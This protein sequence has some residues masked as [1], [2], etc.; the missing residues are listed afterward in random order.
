MSNPKSPSDYNTYSRE[1]IEELKAEMNGFPRSEQVKILAHITGISDRQARRIYSKYFETGVS[2]KEKAKDKLKKELNELQAAVPAENRKVNRLYWDIETSPNIG[3]FWKAGWDLNV[4]AESITQE[5]KIICIGYKWEHEDH[6]H[7]LHWDESQDD[8]ALLIKFLEIVNHADELIHHNGDRFDLPWFKTRCLFHGL[9]PMP[10]YKTIDS[11]AIARRKFYFNSNKLNYI[12]KY[13]GL[14]EK[15][16]T[17]LDL[18]KDI[19]FKKCPI[20]MKK[21]TDYCKQDVVLLEKVWDKMKIALATKTHAGVMEG[22]PSWSCP[23]DGSTNVSLVKRKVT[24]GGTSA[25]QMRCKECNGYYTINAAAY[26]SYLESKG[27]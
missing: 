9:I 23:R 16:K 14:G 2:Y 1:V 7:V 24:A 12:A 4:S 10:D 18:W 5:R 20:A 13:F 17:D 15:L 21:M 8:K 3:F 26:K 19:V 6:A 11:C 22:Q 27:N 25:Y